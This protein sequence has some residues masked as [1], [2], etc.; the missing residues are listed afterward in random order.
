MSETKK[1]KNYQIMESEHPW[2]MKAVSELGQAGRAEGPLDDKTVELVQMAAA[3]ALKLEGAVH[4]HT[5]R[6]LKAGAS[7]EEIHHT[8]VVLTSTMG[9]PTVAAAMSWARDITD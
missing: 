6:A 4:S 3:A 7:R 5:R 9:F 2:L 8:L 1:P